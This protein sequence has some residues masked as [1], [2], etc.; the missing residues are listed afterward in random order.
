V[1]MIAIVIVIVVIVVVDLLSWVISFEYTGTYGTSTGPSLS[2]HPFGQRDH[3]SSCSFLADVEVSGDWNPFTIFF[4][5]CSF[6]LPFFFWRRV[7][8]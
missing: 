6:L 7:S 3:V 8:V 4:L 2:C 1:S 5:P